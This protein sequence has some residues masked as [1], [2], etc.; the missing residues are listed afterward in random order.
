[1]SIASNIQA[2]RVSKS[3]S[4]MG[5]AERAGLPVASLGVVEGLHNQIRV[6]PRRSDGRRN[7]AYRRLKVL[8][9]MLDPI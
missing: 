6:L 8:T 9:Y 5:L 1:M 7:E 2:W 4:V 3:Q